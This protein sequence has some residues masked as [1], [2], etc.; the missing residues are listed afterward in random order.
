MSAKMSATK[1][2]TPSTGNGRRETSVASVRQSTPLRRSAGV[3]W[4]PDQKVWSKTSLGGIRLTRPPDA[5]AYSREHVVRFLHGAAQ[6]NSLLYHGGDL[7]SDA[8][9][10]PRVRCKQRYALIASDSGLLHLSQ[11]RVDE[12]F[13]HYYAVRTADPVSTAPQKVL[14]GDV[15]P[16]DYIA[17]LA[18]YERQAAQ[19]TSRAIRDALG[20]TDND[21]DIMHDK[22]VLRGWLSSGRSPSLTE[23]GLSLLI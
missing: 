16:T 5:V 21:A 12:G 15:D 20:V 2:Q 7:A 10:D 19:S 6:G 11:A 1:F 23:Q 4:T 14:N 13:C 17:L 18:V 9:H 8:A 22:M 3:G